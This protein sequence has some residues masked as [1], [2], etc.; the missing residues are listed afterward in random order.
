[1]SSPPEWRGSAY[2][3]GRFVALTLGSDS[4]YVVA[5]I[6]TSKLGAVAAGVNPRLTAGERDRCIEVAEPALVIAS[7]EDVRRLAIRGSRV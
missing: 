5:Y 2:A 4:A 1:M 6:A 7:S 3:R